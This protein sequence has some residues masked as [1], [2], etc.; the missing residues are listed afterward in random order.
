MPVESNR[1]RLGFQSIANDSR[2][3]VELH[4]SRLRTARVALARSC[5]LLP[6]ARGPFSERC[7]N[8][9]KAR[10]GSRP[11]LRRKWTLLAA[12]WRAAGSTRGR[13]LVPAN[14]AACEPSIDQVDLIGGKLHAGVLTAADDVVPEAAGEHEDGCT[15][16]EP[17]ILL[18]DNIDNEADIIALDLDADFRASERTL[19]IVWWPCIWLV[20]SSLASNVNNG[21]VFGRR[22]RRRLAGLVI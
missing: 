15:L 4:R 3:F 18:A 12:A 14:L 5:R 21:A 9:I 11:R 20:A 10:F 1:Q 16:L 6:P 13:G 17:W 2:K 8:S 7:P 22:Q 19:S